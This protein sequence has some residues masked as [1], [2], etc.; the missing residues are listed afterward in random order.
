MRP[1][2]EL[3]Q[4]GAELIGNDGVAAAIEIL[5]VAIE[6]LETAGVENITVDLTLPDLVP[7]LAKSAFPV[8]AEQIE[9]VRSEL[10]EKDAGAITALGAEAYLPLIHAAGP[11]STALETMRSIDAGG[12]LKSRLDGIAAIAKALSGRATL[13]LDPTERHGF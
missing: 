10:D 12:D 4:A 2:R 3:L 6:A 11:V 13:T 7:T 9:A 5:S 1:E 8:D